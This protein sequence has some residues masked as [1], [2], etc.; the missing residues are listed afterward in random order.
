MHLAIDIR[1]L[2][3]DQHSGIGRYTIEIIKRITKMAP[4]DKFTLFASGSSETLS[5][6]P[7]FS[8]KNV[9]IVKHE[10]PNRVLSAKLHF[11]AHTLEDFLPEK[12]DLWFF[13]N[14]N[15]I[16]T[17]R[18]YVITM[19][20]LSF[21]LFPRFFRIK[22][23]I[24]HGAAGPRSLAE[25]AELVFAVSENTKQNLSS[26]W[27]LSEEQIVTTPLGV[28]DRFEIKIQPCDKNHLR[29]HG[30]N[31]PYILSLC[32]LEPRKNIE[33][34]VE[35]YE[36]WRGQN[37]DGRTQN[38]EKVPH[39]VIAGGRGW[40]NDYLHK[41]IKKSDYASDIHVLGYI[42]EKHKP[43]LYRHAKLFLFPSF[44]EGFGLPIVEAIASGTN[45]VTSFTG[46]MQEVGKEHVIYVDPFNVNDL[47]H[48]IDIGLKLKHE[49]GTHIPGIFSWDAAA[50][51]TLMA[52]KA[53][54]P[55]P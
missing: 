33:T 55:S 49:V 41:R 47:V 53:L 7:K 48:A 16:K 12:P 45:V 3:T 17:H 38:T 1:H 31:F 26:L 42:K 43:T 27:Q 10:M 9:E 15:I 44:F 22:D 46:S 37:T 20:D 4:E 30:I 24:W 40:K 6:L 23:R 18:P 13:P 50:K 19:H 32:T 39:L 29:S 51:R 36:A 21:E 2:T 25:Q 14:I 8:G 34:I 11:T 54:E 5:K 52:I 35:A 28:D